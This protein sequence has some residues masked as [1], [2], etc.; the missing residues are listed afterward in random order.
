[1][2]CQTRISGIA[3]GLLLAAPVVAEMRVE[4]VDRHLDTA[5]AFLAYTEFELSGEPLAELLGLDLDV[6]DPYQQDQPTGFDYVAGI[7]SYEYS[8]EAMYAVNYQSRIGPHLVNGPRNRA[9]GH[10]HEV[11]QE[12]LAELAESVGFE[13]ADLP[14]NLY[15]ISVPYRRAMAA[16]EGDVDLRTTGSDTLV[17]SDATGTQKEVEALLPAYLG[18]YASLGWQES[19]MTR[20]LEPAAIGG[21]LLKE[22]MWAQDFLGGMHVIESDEEVEA[23]SS[24]MDHTGKYALGVSAADGVNGVILTEIS[25]D[26]LQ[27]L[28]SQLAYDG[29]DLGAKI[30][31]GYDPEKQAIWFPHR[32]AVTEKQQQGVKGMAAM[33]VVDARSRLRDTWLLLWPVSEFLGFSEQRQAAGDVNP[34]FRAVFDGHPFAAAPAPNRDASFDNDKV[35]D[36]GFSMAMNLSQMLFRNLQSLHFNAALGTLVDIWDGKPGQHVSTYDVAYSL[37]ALAIFQRAQDALPVGYASAGAG[38]GLGTPLGQEALVLLRRQADFIVDRLIAENGLASDGA[39]FSGTQWMLDKNQSLDAQ[40]AV[41][42]GL[43]A[44]FVATGDARY[45]QA[46]RALYITLD[47]QRYDA[48]LG[49]W[50]Q[51]VHTPWTAAAISSGLRVAMLQ[52]RNRGS[53]NAPALELARLA[54]RYTAWFRTI[55]NGSS[56]NQGMQLAEWPGDSGDHF[57]ASS[58]AVR[59]SGKQK[60]IADGPLDQ[61]ADG[62]ALVGDAPAV[63]ASV[64]RV[65]KK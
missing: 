58:A 45:R 13:V 15:P 53:E 41:I 38:E 49:T 51:D 65:R 21:M 5:G 8:E 31:P 24:H 6:L 20:E 59:M 22:V 28:Q 50:R 19:G 57:L 48:A 60:M 54:D 32:L 37:V 2:T 12:R 36:D 40:F 25:L 11:L 56:V 30:Q 44:A 1:M 29:K 46:A 27:M 7:E 23:D 64:V 61:D 62:V 34:A 17:W 35:S 3:L 26:K 43:G 55:I 52:L 39:S 16:F 63:M 18:D 9:R 42:R 10:S 33:R 47:E 14:A 4:V